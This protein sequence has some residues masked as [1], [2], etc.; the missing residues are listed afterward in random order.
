MC[1]VT[2]TPKHNSKFGFILTSNRDE[3]A[4]R[5]A[6]PPDFYSESQI[7]MLYPKDKLAGGT[8]I[9]LSDKKRIICL[10]NG[11][12]KPHKRLDSYRKSRGVVVK[13]FLSA[14]TIDTE[15]EE[16]DLD[17]IEPF[18]IVAVDWNSELR[19]IELV[20]DG[21]RKHYKDLP[22]K[23]HIWSSSPLYSSEMKQLRN[24]WFVEFLQKE[25]LSA[26]A[27]WKFHTTAG[28]GNAEI[29]VIM[30]RGF[31]KT[32]NISQFEHD[33]SKTVMRYMDLKNR[34]KLNFAF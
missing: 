25:N 29:D 19:F 3:A 12:F 23:P 21:V 16:Y 8:W 24:N 6:L 20:W 17:A 13:D 33:Q 30:D 18:T 14:N 22:L 9:G 7:K 26:E 28:I 15:V 4:N 10:L 11:E 34:E 1:T 32:Q 2:L 27:F 5:E 31:V